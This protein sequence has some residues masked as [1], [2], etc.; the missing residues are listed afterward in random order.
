[1]TDTPSNPIHPHAAGA[2][3]ATAG[4]GLLQGAA[5]VLLCLWTRTSPVR[6]RDQLSPET[7]A[8]AALGY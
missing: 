5:F 8:S 2:D 4:G 6:L 3:R 1:M 7:G